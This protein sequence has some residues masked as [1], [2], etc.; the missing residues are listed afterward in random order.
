MKKKKSYSIAVLLTV[1]SILFFSNIITAQDLQLKSQPGYVKSMFIYQPSGKETHM[2]HS[3]TIVETANHNIIAAWFGGKGEHDP[4]CQIWASTYSN[5][6]WNTPIVIA[7]NKSSAGETK[8]CWNPVLFRLQNNDLVLFYKVGDRP[9]YWWGMF[10][11]SKDNGETWSDPQDLPSGIL[12]P[13]RNKPI[14]LDNG[15]L[16]CP[17]SFETHTRMWN[18][19]FN[20]LENPTK[21]GLADAKWKIIGPCNESSTPAPDTHLSSWG[22]QAIQP[23]ILKYGNG[24]L[25]ALSRTRQ[26]R[27]SE[28]WSEDNGNSWNKMIL[29]DLPNPDSGI[30]GVTLKDGR[31]LLCYNKSEG[32]NAE[33]ESRTPLNVTI[34]K[35]GEIWN[36]VIILE[37]NSKGS[38]SYPS[39][40][41]SEN[42]YVHITYTYEDPSIEGKIIKYVI[43]DPSKF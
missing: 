11:I 4:S 37:N 24:K 39:V 42:G 41:Q 9:Y 22:I 3:S 15:D 2:A 32:K 30:D 6:K 16:L 13:I 31:Q 12:G 8:P 33:G 38:Y 28:I 5:S 10:K 26:K 18:V 29:T 1:L 40:I 23:T 25:Q 21:L 43:L 17:T 20:I 34:S 27:I 35:D 14:Q 36:D 7:E 19:Y